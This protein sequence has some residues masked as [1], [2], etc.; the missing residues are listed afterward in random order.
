[1]RTPAPPP[2]LGDAAWGPLDSRRSPLS[3][4]LP[5]RREWRIDDATEPWTVA[6]HARSESEL[7]VRAWSAPRLATPSDC[8]AQ[9]RL[10]RP[11]IPPADAESLLEERALAAPAGF[12]ARVLVGVRGAE[13]AHT[14]E[15][16]VLAFGASPGHCWALVFTTRG[17]GAGAEESIGRRLGLVSGGTVPNARWRG[18]ADRVERIRE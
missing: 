2:D 6:R 18:I 1:V 9:A 12:H 17:R 10:W 16:W 8:E 4:P 7:R 5:A 11:A 3:V 13:P 15:G 14:L